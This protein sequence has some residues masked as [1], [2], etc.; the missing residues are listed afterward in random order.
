MEDLTKFNTMACMFNG[1]KIDIAS[2]EIAAWAIQNG[3][4][5]EELDK[6]IALESFIVEKKRGIVVETLKKMSRLPQVSPKLF[7][8]FQL[9]DLGKEAQKNLMSLKT[10]AFIEAKQNVIMVGPTGT[11]KTH[12]AQAISNECCSRGLKAYFIKMNELKEKFEIALRQGTTGSLLNAMSKYSCL[13]VDEVGYG[14]FSPEETL[15]FFHLVDRIKEKQQ[16]SMVFT[17][18]KQMSDWKEF[19]SNMDALECTLDRIWDSAICINFT[20]ESFRG[21]NNTTMSFDFNG[22]LV[23][24]F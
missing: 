5:D 4:S 22:G 20:G 11:G 10:L 1:L 17:S 9:R 15:L 14:R 21:Q 8:N 18:N 19:F 6:V 16:G 3:V 13:I 24:H 2:E 23:Q 7:D 12:I